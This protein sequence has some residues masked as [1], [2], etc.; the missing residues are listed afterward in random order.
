[1]L[2]NKKEDRLCVASKARETYSTYLLDLHRMKFEV[3]QFLTMVMT[4][5]ASGG[6]IET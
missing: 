1:M 6:Q 4:T 2:L 5:C 3:C